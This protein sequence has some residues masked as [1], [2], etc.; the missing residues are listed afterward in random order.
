MKIFPKKITDIALKLNFKKAKTS[1]VHLQY[2]QNDYIGTGARKREEKN[3]Q[4]FKSNKIH[5]EDSFLRRKKL[6][7]VKSKLLNG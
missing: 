1:F 3:D 5:L 4:E 2:S 6:E 7:F